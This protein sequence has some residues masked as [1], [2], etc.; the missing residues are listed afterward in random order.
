MAELMLVIN[1]EG[2]DPKATDGDCCQAF[3]NRKVKWMHAQHLA[4]PKNMTFT[5]D[6]LRPKNCLCRKVQ[7]SIF[8]KKFERISK[9][10]IQVT[11]LWTNE[12]NIYSDITIPRMDVEQ[13]IK[14]RMLS[15]AHTVYGVAGREFWFGGKT[16]VS[17]P[18]V[19]LA[20]THITHDTGEISTDSKY[21]LWNAGRKELKSY[22]FIKVNDFLDS[23]AEDIIAPETIQFDVS[24]SRG[25]KDVKRLNLR[26]H[27]GRVIYDAL[28]LP[29]DIKD[30]RDKNKTIDIRKD[31]IL[32]IDTIIDIKPKMKKADKLTVIDKHNLPENHKAAARKKV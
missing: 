8:E 4:H 26:K 1:P 27:K 2:K 30:I 3:N 11:N 7:E 10:E 25:R 31:I 6:G 20:W 29:V 12:V 9:K 23:I 14:N 32:D 19:D 16:N 5:S 15:D 22:L 13:H 18:K 21:E 28:G 24:E 17:L